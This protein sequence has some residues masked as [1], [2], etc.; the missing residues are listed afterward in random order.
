[1]FYVKVENSIREYIV[2][3]QGY[4][5]FVKYKWYATSGKYPYLRAKANGNVLKFHIELMK[6]EMVNEITDSKAT[7]VVVDHINGNVYDNRKENLRVV[8]QSENNMNKKLQENNSSGIVGVSWH[9]RDM[10]WQAYISYNSQ[11]IHL[12]SFYFLRNAVKARREAELDYFGNHSFYNRDDDYQALINSIITLPPVIEPIFTS[13]HGEY[14]INGVA[15]YKNGFR[16]R[17][18]VNGLEESKI[19]KDL[20]SAIVWRENKEIE[21]Y[22][23]KLMF[24]DMRKEKMI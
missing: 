14:G 12:G 18:F 4:D 10:C 6:N 5:L 24:K 19:F 13:R 16:A 20:T 2:D 8:T 22:G 11:R 17:I 1:M 23:Q 21:A 3:E 9:T 7:R 15:D